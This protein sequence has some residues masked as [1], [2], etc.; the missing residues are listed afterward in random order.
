MVNIP[1]HA[2]ILTLPK[3]SDVIVT[4]ESYQKTIRKSIRRTKTISLPVLWITETL[5]YHTLNS[6]RAVTLSK[7]DTIDLWVQEID[8]SKWWRI[9]SELRLGWYDEITGE[10]LFEKRKISE[11]RNSLTNNPYSI[12]N[13][14]FFDPKRINTPLSF[15][16]KVDGVVRTSGADNRSE[17]KNILVIE[18]NIA[19][20]IPYSWENLRD[21][22]G[23]FAMVNLAL[24]EWHY[25][26][27]PIGRT[28]VCL[29]NPSSQ[30][31]SSILLVFTASAMTEPELE[32]E[33]L[34]WWC[35]RDS[36]SKLDS[37]GSTQLWF[38]GST[39]YG[40]S[41]KWNPDY[42]NIPH[43]LIVYD[44]TI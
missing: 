38:E 43:S 33:I 27:E 12:F 14:Q 1:V 11:V 13:G 26:N 20:I 21:A 37:S 2:E 16:I 15:G 41:H 24:G 44:V 25:K 40:Y 39:I 17:S 19:K 8:L 7:Y 28:Y 5:S 6:G 4:N 9:S 30:N 10:P 42:R 35:T 23:Y 32:R 18:K 31:E 36:T 3:L 29:R 22:P 34:R